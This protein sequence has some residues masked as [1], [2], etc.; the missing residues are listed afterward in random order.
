L[1]I[2]KINPLIKKKINILNTM[3]IL[4]IVKKAIIIIINRKI[5]IIKIMIGKINLIILIAKISKTDQIIVRKKAMM[6]K[7]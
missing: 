3:I 4:N 5:K 6:C 7:P 1:I 2:K